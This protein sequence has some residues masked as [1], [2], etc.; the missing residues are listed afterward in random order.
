MKGLA[1]DTGI[2]TA[3]RLTPRP[4]P[5]D[6]G[7]MKHLYARHRLDIRRTIP[8]VLQDQ[9]DRARHIVQWVVR[10]RAAPL[11]SE[12]LMPREQYE[13]RDL[14]FPEFIARKIISSGLFFRFRHDYGL[15]FGKSALPNGR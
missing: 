2:E 13:A 5:A 14:A 4:K 3:P 11:L 10:R 1:A 9:H 7:A 8:R 12:H 6:A 15:G